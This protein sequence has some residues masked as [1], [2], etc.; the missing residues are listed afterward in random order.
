MRFIEEH[1]E[2]LSRVQ[3]LQNSLNGAFHAFQNALNFIAFLE[4][5]SDTEEPSLER[6]GAYN[7]FLQR[8]Q[9]LENDI[10]LLY[11]LIETLYLEHEE[12]IESGRELFLKSIGTLQRILPTWAY[13][14]VTRDQIVLLKKSSLGLALNHTARGDG[15]I[16]EALCENTTLCKKGSSARKIRFK[17]PDVLIDK[18]LIDRFVRLNDKLAPHFRDAEYKH[19]LKVL[20]YYS[21]LVSNTM[22]EAGKG[23]RL[24]DNNLLTEM[25]MVSCDF[26][27]TRAEEYEQD[28]K[29]LYAS[30]AYNYALNAFMNVTYSAKE[31]FQGL[32][33]LKESVY[34]NHAL[35][36]FR[37]APR[38]F[39]GMRY[40][41]EYGTSEF[42]ENVS[43]FIDR[44]AQVCADLASKKYA[45]K[46]KE[47]GDEFR[48]ISLDV[49]EFKPFKADLLQDWRRASFY[50][51]IYFTLG[52]DVGKLD[53]I[54]NVFKGGNFEPLCEIANEFQQLKALEGQRT[55]R[56]DFLKNQLEAYL[57]LLSDLEHEDYDL[58]LERVNAFLASFLEGTEGLKGAITE[59]KI[60][61][62]NKRKEKKDKERRRAERLAKAL[63]ESAREE[64]ES[65]MREQERLAQEQK[66]LATAGKAA[67]P[68]REQWTHVDPSFGVLDGHQPSQADVR[69]SLSIKR[70]RIKTR[71]EEG[72][73]SVVEVLL[74]SE[75]P[76][77]G[78]PEPEIQ[79]RWDKLTSRLA[80]A[81]VRTLEDIFEA[82]RKVKISISEFESLVN[83]LGGNLDKS[84]GAGSHALVQLFDRDF[85]EIYQ[86]DETSL[87]SDMTGFRTVSRT[88]K[89][90]H[91]TR[92]LRPE[93]MRDILKS[94]CA[95][96]IT[97]ESYA[98]YRM[99]VQPEE[100]GPRGSAPPS[101][102]Q[103]LKK[104][105]EKSKKK[106]K[107]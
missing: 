80:P 72:T 37:L 77:K 92:T 89:R 12:V 58:E 104:E 17:N 26:L 97:P 25:T 2:A 69:E 64:N 9:E 14:Y 7:L 99:S 16:M 75:T 90:G 4:L 35:P 29:E 50:L 30:A 48:R 45:H 11:P 60:E 31:D 67:A 107:K 56:F 59:E 73:G 44:I 15:P 36:F 95:V 51:G 68:A 88:D 22:F 65:L 55:F 6:K 63:R 78:Y 54:L 13:G 38:V 41:A 28:G 3:V 100:S 93:Q 21:P 33:D 84:R 74:P 43:L 47:E 53:K 39:R 81:H 8:A 34:D 40:L 96:G 86:I 87:S 76:L 24:E 66:R 1:Y 71:P 82:S 27:L 83:A 52:G 32:E 103:D 5:F 85:I 61:R 42:N 23:K 94:F 62:E 105:G 10:V 18:V 102:S 19:L 101:S 106:K 46:R 91:N 57:Q 20:L 49:A 98:G 70:E 79:F